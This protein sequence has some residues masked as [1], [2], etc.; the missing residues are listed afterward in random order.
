LL[1]DADKEV[2]IAALRALAAIRASG[3]SAAIQKLVNSSD[4]QVQREAR[5]ALRAITAN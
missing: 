4:Y 5:A 3:A 1:H 2:V